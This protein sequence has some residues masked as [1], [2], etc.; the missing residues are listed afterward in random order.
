MLYT[1]QG[2]ALTGVTSYVSKSYL[3]RTEKLLKD[4]NIIC[5]MFDAPCTYTHIHTRTYTCTYA[6]IHI[7]IHTHV[8]IHIY[9]HIYTHTHA[10]TY[11]YMHTVDYNY[12]ASC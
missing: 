6:C 4:I 11:I 10:H 7:Y 9:T 1:R 3:K 12:I 5:T 2:V 8:C